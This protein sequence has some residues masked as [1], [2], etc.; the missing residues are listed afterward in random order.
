MIFQY[1]RSP[2][3]PKLRGG[4]PLIEITLCHQ[5]RKRNVSALVDSG[6]AMSVLPYDIGVELGFAWN[7]QTVP[8]SVGGVLKNTPAYGVL[9]YGE[10]ASFPSVELV[11]AWVRQPSK[12]VRTILGQM[13]FFQHYKITFEGYDE[14]F[15]IVPRGTLH[16]H[17]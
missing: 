15:E 10:L 6:A 5:D 1:T 2:A 7:E 13:N 17:Q 8:V 14:I 4:L 3:F 16:R 9:V 12:D 11:F